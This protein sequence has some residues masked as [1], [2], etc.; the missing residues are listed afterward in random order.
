M[1]RVG[2]KYPARAT[3]RHTLPQFREASPPLSDCEYRAAATQCDGI[4][5][6][7]ARAAN[8]Y[9]LAHRPSRSELSKSGSRRSVIAAARLISDPPSQR[10]QR[11]PWSRSL[12]GARRRAGF[13]LIPSRHWILRRKFFRFVV[14]ATPSCELVCCPSCKS[15]QKD[16]GQDEQD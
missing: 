4:R 12:A 16:L 6:F 7:A 14:G 15:C 13:F 10:A 9:G 8:R 1:P 5:R 3:C 11:H 2:C